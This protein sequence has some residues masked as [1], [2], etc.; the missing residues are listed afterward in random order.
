MAQFK[1]GDKM[2]NSNKLRIFSG[3]A[4]LVLCLSFTTV[5]LKADETNEYV[6]EDGYSD[7]Q[8]LEYETEAPQNEKTYM[9]GRLKQS[10]VDQQVQSYSEMLASLLQ[11]SDAEIAV[12]REQY[13]EQVGYAGLFDTFDEIKEMELGDFEQVNQEN[14]EV[15][16][17]AED[18]ADVLFDMKFKKGTV[19]IDLKLG[20]YEK[21]GTVFKQI[22]VGDRKNAKK[23]KNAGKE[24]SFKEKMSEAGANTLMGMGT[25]FGVLIFMSLIISLFGFIPKITEKL[26]KKEQ[27]ATAPAKEVA[28]T[29]AAQQADETEMDQSELIAVITAAI[30]ASEQKS[31][32]SFVVRSIKRR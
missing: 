1:R 12:V 3:I 28:N 22:S 4:L 16:E 15:I 19:T 8:G 14:I 26:S 2:K 23:I 13:A 20:C 6:A 29:A 21:L 18:V 11:F 7:V 10:D 27:K 24:P 32:D 5:S 31:T 25:V 30:V 9:K 17:G